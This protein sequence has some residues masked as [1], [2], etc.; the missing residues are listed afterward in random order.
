MSLKLEKFN[1][2]LKEL[3]MV[4]EMG[5]I[6]QDVKRASVIAVK[7]AFPVVMI[8]MTGISIAFLW[9]GMKGLPFAFRLAFTCGLWTLGVVYGGGILTTVISHIIYQFI[10]TDR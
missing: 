7:I 10:K 1:K 3:D 9:P 6:P 5:K 8:V 4:S 2:E